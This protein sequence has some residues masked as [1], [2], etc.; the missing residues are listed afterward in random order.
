M[1]GSDLLHSLLKELAEDAIVIVDAPPLI[2]VTDAAVLSTRTDGV[3]VVVSA[4]QTTV[5]GLEAATRNVQRANGKVLAVILNR[6]PLRVP[7][8]LNYGYGYGGGSRRTCAPRWSS[9]RSRWPAG[10]A[11]THLDDRGCHS[12]AGTGSTSIRYGERLA[13][14]G[15]TP[16]IGTV[17]DSYDNALAETVN[18]YDTTEL[19]RG[20]AHSGPWKTVED[21]EL[22]TLGWVHWHNAQRLHGYLPDIPP[23]EFEQTF[24]AHQTDRNLLVGTT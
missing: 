9:T 2:A 16:S 4:G 10:P 11:G 13:Q 19:V 1:L 15:A 21:L 17:G 22:V 23:G 14:I 7:D 12:D 3:L 24:Y 8:S 18:G 6:V 5:G 20:P